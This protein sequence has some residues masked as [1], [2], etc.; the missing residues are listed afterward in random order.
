MKWFKDFNIKLEILSLIE[1]K[2]GNSLKCMGTGENFPNKTPI[3]QVLRSTINKC[4]LRKLKSL[5]KAKDTINRT[6]QQPTGWE[7]IFT[8]PASDR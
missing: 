7:K 8:N 5:C 4:D 2:V 1:E 6:K 3:S